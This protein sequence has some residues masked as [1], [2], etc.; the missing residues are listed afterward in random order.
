MNSFQGFEGLTLEVVLTPVLRVVGWN[1]HGW[2][3]A[4]QTWVWGLGF[5]V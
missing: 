4:L 5:R 2:Y 3:K 1:L